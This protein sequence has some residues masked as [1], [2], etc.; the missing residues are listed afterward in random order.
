M[1]KS[2]RF[3]L[4]KKKKDVFIGLSCFSLFC[5]TNCYLNIIVIVS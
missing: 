2:M 3:D 5:Q 1:G 4:N